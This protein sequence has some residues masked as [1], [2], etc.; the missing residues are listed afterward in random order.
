MCCGSYDHSRPLRALYK[1]VES[2]RVCKVV[3]FILFNVCFVNRNFQQNLALYRYRLIQWLSFLCV[4]VCV[5]VCHC[6]CVCV[7]VCVCDCVC[8]C[9][10]D[11]VCVVVCMVHLGATQNSSMWAVLVG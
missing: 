1:W 11:C 3:G 2:Q 5:C 9:V 6:V 10:C 4:C 7:C 8:V